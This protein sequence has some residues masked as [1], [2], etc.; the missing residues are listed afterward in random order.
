MLRRSYSFVS[1]PSIEDAEYPTE[2]YTG[3]LN[4]IFTWYWRVDSHFK[5]IEVWGYRDALVENDSGETL[6]G[7]FRRGYVFISNLPDGQMGSFKGITINE[8]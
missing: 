7:K 4:K 1:H 5:I 8:A 2:W 6:I 3:I